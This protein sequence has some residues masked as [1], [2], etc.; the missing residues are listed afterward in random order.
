MTDES[1]FEVIVVG[2]GIAGVSAAA[3]LARTRRTLLIER[4][5]QPG[6][7]TTGRSAALYTP[8]YGV[9]V[10]RQ[11]N[12]AGGA[13]YRDPPPGFADHPLLTPRG[14]M[15]IAAGDG[16]D[17]H[18]AEYAAAR[19]AD[20]AVSRLSPDAARDL[21]P[22]LR[23]GYLAA[24]FLD[25]AA[26]DM[27]VNSILQGF[28]RQL[29]AL[30]GTIVTDA[31]VTGIERRDGLWRVALGERTL[32]APALVNAAG[33]WADP[34][35]A[36]AGLPA[37]GIEPRR[38]TALIVDPPAGADIA[39]WP[40]VA[41]LP[42]TFYFKPDAGRLMCS[43]ADE[44]PDLPGDAQPDE[45]DIAV[46]VER[47]QAACDLPVQRIA[48]SWAGLRSFAPDRTP[49]A[50]FEPG[51]DGFFWLAGQGGYGIMTAP[52][53]AAI[54]AHLVAGAALP[55]NLAALDLARLSPARLR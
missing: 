28:L 29:R 5:S 18:E 40:A 32:A 23:P 7:H 34:I 9:P 27:D 20:P 3:A 25:P 2:G 30:G 4:E 37:L 6:Y 42:E 50:G 45:M 53:L 8:H 54:T 1:P 49:V 52:A 24:A 38:R 51:R 55:A 35:A 39:R 16:L 43:P 14:A 19:A 46:C 44:T 41:N 22:I 12:L 10:V 13:F 48:R 47:V 17:L 31:H 36:L 11:L 21:V 15:Y 26:A 33:A